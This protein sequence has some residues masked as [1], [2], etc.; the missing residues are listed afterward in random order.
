M[1]RFRGMLSLGFLGFLAACAAPPSAAQAGDA[2]PQPQPRS[3][4]V[5]VADESSDLISRVRFDGNVAVEE[6]T[7]AVGIMPA[8]LDGAHGLAVSPR[9][10]YWY[11]SWLTARRSAK[12]GN[13]PQESIRWSIPSPWDHSQPRWPS[14]LTAP[15]CLSSISTCMVGISFSSVSAVLRHSCVSPNALRHASCRTA[16]RSLMTAGGISLPA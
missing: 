11:I 6:K 14:P 15:G 1:L 13:S 5:Y 3:Y 2:T 10:D 4:T 7:I 16:A 8:D 9:G 12:C